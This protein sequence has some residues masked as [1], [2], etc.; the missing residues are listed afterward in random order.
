MSEAKD[1]EG[2]Q[3]PMPHFPVGRLIG[4][5]GEKNVYEHPNDPNLVRGVFF[6]EVYESAAE[7]ESRYCLARLLHCLLPNQIPD[8]LDYSIPDTSRGQYYFDIQRI[9]IDETL[10]ASI[11]TRTPE[12]ITLKD[13]LG[14]LGVANLD[15]SIGI[16]GNFAFDTNGNFWYIDQVSPW[17]NQGINLARNYDPQAIK[18]RI[19]QLTGEEQKTVEQYYQRLEELYQDELKTEVEYSN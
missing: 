4:H 10:Q 16:H 17:V 6:G 1:G 3:P 14:K 2:I 18:N 5:G 9:D 12:C 7:I 13:E 15:P 11:S 8:I 19:E